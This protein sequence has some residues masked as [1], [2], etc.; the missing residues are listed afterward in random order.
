MRYNETFIT[1]SR[2]IIIIFIYHYIYSVHKFVDE[3]I[4]LL[5]DLGLALSLLV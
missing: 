1:L 4:K 2:F 5:L 3:Y